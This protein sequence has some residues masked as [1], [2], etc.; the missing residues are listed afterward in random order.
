MG[1]LNKDGVNGK[2]GCGGG[3]GYQY[4]WPPISMK[5]WPPLLAKDK[6]V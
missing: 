3:C 4:G 6:S 5:E 2:G 1:R